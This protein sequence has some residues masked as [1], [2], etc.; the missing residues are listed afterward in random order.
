MTLP[1]TDEQKLARIERWCPRC[2]MRWRVRD[3]SIPPR[4]Y[5]SISLTSANLAYIRDA[6]RVFDA[7]SAAHGD[8]WT[9]E[10]FVDWMSADVRERTT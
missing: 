10:E 3:E 8:T 2:Q 1:L 5:G 9:A 4:E 6:A 7:I